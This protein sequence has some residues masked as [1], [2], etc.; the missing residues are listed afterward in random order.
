[1][2]GKMRPRK[3]ESRADMNARLGASS[4]PS[5]GGGPPR[6]GKSSLRAATAFGEA[7]VRAEERGDLRAAR[8]FGRAESREQTRPNGNGRR[9]PAASTSKVGS[10]RFP[11]SD[12]ITGASD[13]V[14]AVPV[15]LQLKGAARTYSTEV[16]SDK[17][18]N[19]RPSLI[20]MFWNSIDF[21]HFQNGLALTT[22][23]VNVPPITN[24]FNQL[25]QMIV[26]GIQAKGIIVPLTDT[27]LASP[28][29]LPTW[30]NSWA[31]VYGLVYGLESML[32]CGNYNVTTTHI[33]DAIMQN[34]P[35]LQALSRRIRSFR[36]PQGFVD[37]IAMMNGVKLLNDATVPI[38]Y[39]STELVTGGGTAPVDLSVAANIAA[40]ITAG[41]NVMNGILPVTATP[42]FARIPNTFAKAYP[43]TN[44]PV[45]G[46]SNDPIEYDWFYNMEAVY[47]DSTASK[48]FSYPNNNSPA[49]AAGPILAAY[50]VFVR[51]EAGEDT[52]AGK[53]A[54]SLW[55]AQV[56][57]VDALAGVA[58]AAANAS[59]IGAYA[60]QIIIA[61]AAQQLQFG[62]YDQA[63][64]FTARSLTGAGPLAL[65]TATAVGEHSY[66]ATE[67]QN[68][69]TSNAGDHRDP[70][71]YKV[72]YTSPAWASD[73]TIRLGEEWFLST[74]R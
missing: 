70:R 31:N 24:W 74:I 69:F 32:T 10:G 37:Y 17:F 8:K 54:M 47:L 60:N 2:A 72:F 30:L 44:Y 45:A 34:L 25:Y 6:K 7:E 43:D 56:Y 33:N 3:G 57:S 41:E 9:D 26:R 38:W 64:V 67:A 59:Y 11:P 53:L 50:P 16:Y 63:G 61:G 27:F 51:N 22:D 14:F 49:N 1:M 68:E 62:E 35:L 13:K 21:L 36:M 52:P 48:Y 73:E 15:Q 40:L 58:S 66:W 5:N 20:S 4:A 39:L 46:V 65:S 28:G 55:K 71:S 29:N 23:T 19:Q 12:L 18:F 42:D